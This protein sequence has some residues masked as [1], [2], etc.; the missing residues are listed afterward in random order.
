[1]SDQN[2]REFLDF[3]RKF[4]QAMLITHTVGGQMIARPMMIAEID[5]LG[6][7]WFSTD[8]ASGKVEEINNNPDVC[9]TMT[10][11]VG[12]ATVRGKA[13]V[14]RDLLKIKDLWSETWRVWFPEGPMDSNLVLIKVDA[15]EGEF[16]S[17][18]GIEGWKYLFTMAKSYVRG[19]RP[20]TD[21][22]VH[23]VVQL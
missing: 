18:S 5:S 20:K 19:E 7:F 15:R 10:S 4:D 9:I 22:D 14:V 6:N 11:S 21:V 13:T 12:N 1:M 8:F 16:W 3:C 17:T 23:R 2:A